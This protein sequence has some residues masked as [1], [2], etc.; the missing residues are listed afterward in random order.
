M[1]LGTSATDR[2]LVNAALR[3]GAVSGLV[4]NLSASCGI[5]P[6]QTGHVADATIAVAGAGR[7][8]CVSANGYSSVMSCCTANRLGIR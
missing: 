5:E 6:E 1:R 8:I 3:S 7:G 4:L 2:L